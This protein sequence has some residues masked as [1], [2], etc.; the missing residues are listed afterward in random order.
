MTAHAMTYQP[1]RSWLFSFVSI[2][3]I[4]VVGLTGCKDPYGA[5]A[6]AGAD[7]A[8]AISVG[9]NTVQGLASQ[10]IIT[11]TEAENVLG[12]LEYA[13]KGD[14]AFLSCIA[15]AHATPSKSGAFTT[16]ANV[17]NLTLNNPQQLALIRV[18]DTSA[19]Q[20]VSTIVQGLTTAVTA[21]VAGL[22]GA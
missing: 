3:V 5:C 20:T 6:K 18:S 21:I 16:C 22:K 10:H 2:V 4:C 9:M 14:E 12:Y 11:A 7:I 15:S 1:K 19:S 13:N 17:F 8:S